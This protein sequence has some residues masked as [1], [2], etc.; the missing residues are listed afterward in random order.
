[1]AGN[2]HQR[3]LGDLGNKIVSGA[4]AVGTTM[5]AEDVE[6]DHGVS[7]SVVREAVRVLQALGMVQTTKRVGIRVLPFDRWNL[8]D[9][10]VIGWRLAC[11]EHSAQ[12]RSLVELRATVEPRAAELAALYA[13]DVAAGEL[14]ALAA[15][16]RA[17]A[18]AGDLSLFLRYDVTFHSL[19][20]A[21][22]GNEM[23]AKLDVVS[24]EVL[25][26][27]TIQGLMPDNPTDE[28]LQLHVDVADAI[29]ARRPADARD[30]MERIM[31]STTSAIEGT[32]SEAP[33]L[34]L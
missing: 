6:R 27:R 28:V 15:R 12:L 19:V 7:R 17:V 8:Y 4:L 13:P 1:M 3:L 20:L 14:L 34:F 2:L 24:T 9:P 16:M 10:L 31:Q 18:R 32:W 23:F 5:L 25:N 33:R 26:S 11:D 29:Q 30:A 22:S 21:A